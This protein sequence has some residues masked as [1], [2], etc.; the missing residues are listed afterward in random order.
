M[1]TVLATGIKKAIEVIQAIN[2]ATDSIYYNGK[3][4]SIKRAPVNYPP[5]LETAFLPC[6]LVFPEDGTSEGKGSTMSQT[7]RIFRQTTYVDATA[8]GRFDDPIQLAYMLL[9]RQ[10]ETWLDKQG[11]LYQVLDSTTEYRISLTDDPITDT[12]IVSNLK[13]TREDADYWGYSFNT[14]ILIEWPISC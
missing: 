2:E 8:Q 10:L 6:C 3:N 9:Q 11:Q 14:G 5:S 7:T 1:A 4:Y 13:Y 12:G